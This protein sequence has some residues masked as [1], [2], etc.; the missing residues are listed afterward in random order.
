MSLIVILFATT[1]GQQGLE[2]LTPEERAAVLAIR[3]GNANR[4]RRQA[5]PPSVRTQGGN[6]IVTAGD[7][8][9]VSFNVNGTSISASELP[10]SLRSYTDATVDALGM[11]FNIGQTAGTLAGVNAANR[12]ES[13]LQP[14]IAGISATV[15][16]TTATVGTLGTRMTTVEQAQALKASSADLTAVNASLF[17]AL[18]SLN[19]GAPLGSARNPAT[20]C[21]QIL[22]ARPDAVTSTYTLKFSAAGD[23]A[24][25]T[26]KCD[27][28]TEG[29]GWTRFHSI[30]TGN[31]GGF[32][33]RDEWYRSNMRGGNKCNQEDIDFGHWTF[34]RNAMEN[35]YNE[36]LIMD[37]DV[38][39]KF[40]NRY[41]MYR[42]NHT[43]ACRGNNFFK[44]VTGDFRGCQDAQIYDFTTS[45]YVQTR[46]GPCN[47][48][49]H[50]QWNC[51]PQAGIR[52]HYGTRDCARDGGGVPSLD[53][54]GWWTGFQTVSGGWGNTEM[55]RV[56]KHWNNQWD[57]VP[58]DLFY[59]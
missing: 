33:A 58:T 54:W 50:S 17:E 37:A 45:A 11:G 13:V 42:F 2:G 20:S 39:T 14:Q 24:P 51:H 5:V 25:Y 56:V 4:E 59:R 21:R 6:V 10:A 52:G 53:A 43:A 18:S 8:G 26:I 41:H 32:L 40:T 38:Q 1:L 30:R 35:S 12:V 28:S 3:N 31:G 57:K 22:E 36:L 9:D 55:R 49:Q 46:R 29:G 48:N 7:G 34:S 27:M 19:S 47:T 44:A 23:N 16:E 15:T